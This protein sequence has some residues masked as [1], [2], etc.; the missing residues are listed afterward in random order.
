MVLR[1]LTRVRGRWHAVRMRLVRPFLCN[2]VP[3]YAP[4]RPSAEAATV[5]Y[6]V[7]VLG[8]TDVVVCGHSHCGAMQGLMSKSY[9]EVQSNDLSE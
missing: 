3:P 7:E 8:V 5:E 6:A 1:L 4:G 2:I 9:V